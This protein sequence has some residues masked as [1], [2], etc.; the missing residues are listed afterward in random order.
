MTYQVGRI[1]EAEDKDTSRLRGIEWQK[2]LDTLME[3]TEA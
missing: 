1:I 3:K 2:F